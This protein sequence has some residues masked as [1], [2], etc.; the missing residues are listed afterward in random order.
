MPNNNVKRPS[1]IVCELLPEVP[2]DKSKLR[3]H[4][5]QEV[6]ASGKER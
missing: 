3:Y 2:V 1:L 4:Q 6:S 5:G